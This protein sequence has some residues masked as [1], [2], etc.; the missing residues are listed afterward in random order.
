MLSTSS[1]SYTAVIYYL[2]TILRAIALKTW[3]WR[4]EADKRVLQCL[5]L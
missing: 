3:L 2:C 4:R 5:T 1:A